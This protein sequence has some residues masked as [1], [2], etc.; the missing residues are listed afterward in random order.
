MDRVTF[1][2]ASGIVWL[3]L[4]IHFVAG[5]VS[6][7]AGTVALSVTKGQR[8][9]KRSGLAFTWGMVVLGVTAIGIGAYEES[10]GQVV[11]GFLA[12]YLVFSA[13]TTVKPL[14]AT[15][16]RTDAALMVLA[17]AVAAAML[18]SGVNEWLDPT[19]VVVGRPRVGPPLIGG[20]VLLLAAVGDLRAIRAEG[21]TGSR[22]LARHL[23]RMCFGLFIATGSF[24]LGQMKFIPEPARILPLLLALAFAPIP[25]LLYWMWRVG[26]RG[27]IA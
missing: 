24:F 21:L 11:G 19:V 1:A 23:W 12:A 2:T 3:V 22:R 15:G 5:L 7:V 25:L 9:H 26:V 8:L 6:I 27:R 10:P 4:A 20:T 17:F 18:Y 16:K 13:M 14:P